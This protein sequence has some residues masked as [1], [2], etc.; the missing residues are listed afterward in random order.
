MSLELPTPDLGWSDE[1]TQRRF[2]ALQ[3]KLVSL[4]KAIE[5]LDDE[6]EQTIVVVPSLTVDFAALQGSVLQAYEERFLFLLLLLQQP[7]ARLIY[8]TSQ[9]IHPNVVDYYLGLLPRV[10]T[11]HA[12]ARLHLLA[13]HDGAPQPLS[14]KLLQRPRLIAK[15]R[16][17]IPR[18]DR[19][20]LVPFNTT[21][22]ERDLA[23]RLGIPM[24]GAD[25]VHLHFGTKSGCRQLFADTGVSYPAGRENL[26]SVDDLIDAIVDLRG[27]RPDLRQAMVKHNEGVSGEGNAVLELAGLD[28]SSRNAVYARI[29][30]MRLET[31]AF[32]ID[33]YLEKFERN[34]GI[35]EERIVGAPITSP[36]AQL[37]IT[38]TGRVELLSTHDQLLQGQ[39]YVGCTFPAD[40]A[41]ARVI[42][43]EALKVGEQ[44]LADGVLGRFAIDFVC[45]KTPEGWRPYAIE[46]NLRKGGTTHPFLTLQ[47]LTDGR[48]HWEDGV[49]RTSGGVQRCYLATD[50]LSAPAYRVFTPDDLFDVAVRHGLHY[51]PNRQTGVVFHMMSAI[52]DHGRLG[53]TAVGNDHDEAR[54]FFER[55]RTV[56]ED[57]ARAAM[58]HTPLD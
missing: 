36:S 30:G 28:T 54:S 4:W 6:G 19:A 23:I 15:I 5:T 45:G 29:R 2:D 51:D 33:V 47:F 17:L 1:E 13:P 39:K 31:K 52:G 44:L 49:F 43:E 32:G 16:R 7:R 22:F 42:A 8:V 24:Y 12:R 38:P 14:V 10:I 34:G 56:L 20:H 53:L 55:T 58:V 3:A 57:E 46:L 50:E 41:Y 21:R 27:E 18:A 35:L 11:S 40:A 37:R 26:S 48:Y 25:P 9:P